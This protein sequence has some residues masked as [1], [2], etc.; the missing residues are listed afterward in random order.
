M[1]ENNDFNFSQNEIDLSFSIKYYALKKT[2]QDYK[3]GTLS[4]IISSK[5]QT[6]RREEK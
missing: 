1:I 6:A 4:S 3:V 5:D 2:I